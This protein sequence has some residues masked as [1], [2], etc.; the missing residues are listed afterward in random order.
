VLERLSWQSPGSFLFAHHNR[1]GTFLGASPER[2][3]R[4]EE[5]RIQTDSLAGTRALG[6]TTEET[7]R[8]SGE[9]L[10]SEKDRAE[11]DVVTRFLTD[12]LLSYC[13]HVS[14]DAEPSV[15]RTS[16]LQHLHSR[17]SGDL[18]TGASLDDLLS[19]L[20]P[21][22]A[23]CGLPREAAR[24]LIQNLEYTPRGLYA[25]AVGYVDIKSAEFAVAIRSALVR[26]NRVHLFAGA[27]IVDGS[28]PASEWLETAHKLTPML[29]ALGC[30]TL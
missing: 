22:P 6:R 1:V 9:L 13:E 5:R 20:H 26:E 24:S 21:T 29:R 27:G 2:L 25:G 3:F 23:V 19:A 10:R 14:A 8:L 30:E 17:V 18:R 28:D 7:E 12:A 15:I 16:A 11:Q 4:V